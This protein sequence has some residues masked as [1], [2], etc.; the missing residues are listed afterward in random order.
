MYRFILKR[1][2]M[3]IPVLLGVILVIFSMMYISEGDPARMIL[4]EGASEAEVQELREELGLND[5]FLTRYVNY[6][7]GI[8]TRGDLGTSYVTGRPV[9]EEIFDRWP[10]TMLLAT[11]S[12]L[13]A[14]AIGI[15]AGIISATKQYS[16]FDN[17]AMVLALVGVSMP[18]FWQGLVNI[19][20]FSVYLHWLPPSGFYGPAYWILPAVTIGTSTAA[21]TTRMTRSSMLDV[22]RQDYIRTARAKGLSERVTITRHALKNA[23]IPIIT[24]VGLQFGRGLGG[25]I[26]TESIFSIPGLGKLM[27]DSIKARNYPVVQGGVLFIA[28]AFSLINLIVDILYAF[29]DPRIKSQYQSRG[30]RRKK[31]AGKA[32]E[33]V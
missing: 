9:G 17:T 14:T 3:M 25:A 6:V 26:L 28:I 31:A 29:A 24:T 13:L 32:G 33:E 7:K 30:S 10:T 20:I 12:V 2:L 5:P 23:L 22:I 19:L 8:V 1:I 15:P 11:L 21:T 18:N 4:G 27:V 16:A